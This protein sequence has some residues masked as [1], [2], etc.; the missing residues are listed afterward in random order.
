M[1][2]AK[3][4]CLILYYGLL[5]YLPASNNRYFKFV[6]GFRSKIAALVFTKAG[7]D[8]NVEKGANFG[9]GNDIEIGNNSG[10]GVNCEI[11]GPLKIGNDVMM[12]PEVKIITNSHVFSSVEKPMRLQGNVK[13]G[14]EIGDDVWIGARVII[15]PG[16]KVGS[17]SILAAGAVVTKDVPPFAIV[18]GVPA[19]ILKFRK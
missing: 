9:L 4:L 18:G 15:L 17:G 10:I 19:K 16:V 2:L 8:I 5:I 12:G 14:I 13:R 1:S 3:S 7:K 11:R 6:R